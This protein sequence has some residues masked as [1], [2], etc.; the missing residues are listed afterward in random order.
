MSELIPLSN[1]DIDPSPEQLKTNYINVNGRIEHEAILKNK[2][3]CI[4]LGLDI[5]FETM[6]YLKRWG[7]WLNEK[8]R[9]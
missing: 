7:G 3:K 5:Y 4:E 1:E 9:P 8:E 6:V 2:E